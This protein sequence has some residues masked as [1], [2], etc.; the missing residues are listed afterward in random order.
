MNSESMN[1]LV[2]CIHTHPNGNHL[3]LLP[4]QTIQVLHLVIHHNKL[5]DKLHNYLEN[6]DFL[7]EHNV[8]YL[9]H[10]LHHQGILNKDWLSMLQKQ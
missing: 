9:Q 4:H 1:H 3:L 5:L 7:I 8:H 2:Y 6:L 10:Q